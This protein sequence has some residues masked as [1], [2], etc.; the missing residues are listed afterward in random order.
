[1][2]HF[3][4]PLSAA[5]T[6]F[7]SGLLLSIPVGPINLTIMNEGARR[8]FKYA[9]MIGLG[10]TAMEVIY[11]F[12]AFTG[13]ASFFTQG[14]IKAAM[15]LFSF[16]FMLFLGVKFLLAKSVQ[17]RVVHLGLTADRLEE[18][19][20]ERFHPTSAFMTGLVRVMGNV[21]VLVFWIILAANFI[22]REWVTPDWPG[23]LMCVGGVAVGTGLWFFALSWGISQG[24]GKFSE[25]TLLRMEHLSGV[26]LLVLALIHGGTIMWQMAHHKM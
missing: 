26:G 25:K 17:A 20:G 24:H 23:K 8:G 19:F 22:S 1:M 6:G 2:D 13:F 4:P 16:V 9:A 12:I 18:R 14:Y 5:L 3:P 15:E 10:A 21:G 11:C 7:I